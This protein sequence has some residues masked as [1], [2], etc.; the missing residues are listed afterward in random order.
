MFLKIRIP[1]SMNFH[2]NGYLI[3]HALEVNIFTLHIQHHDEEP[4][5]W[6]RDLTFDY[7]PPR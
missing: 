3:N 7:P 4:E 2:D 6:L 1:V 5:E